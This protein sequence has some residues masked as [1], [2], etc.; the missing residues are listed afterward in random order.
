MERMSRD[1]LIDDSILKSHKVWF[2]TIRNS[3]EPKRDGTPFGQGL[4]STQEHT[5]ETRENW[6]TPQSRSRP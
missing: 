2:G 6:F 3:A 5:R 1:E 4:R